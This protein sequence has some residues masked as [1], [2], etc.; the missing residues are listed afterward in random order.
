MK[1]GLICVMISFLIGCTQFQELINPQIASKNQEIEHL[2]AQL[3][4][5]LQTN[6]AVKQENQKLKSDNFRLMR[7]N[8][9]LEEDIRQLKNTNSKLK[10]ENRALARKIDILK[11]LDHHVEEKR[12]IYTSD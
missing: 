4:K 1:A 6:R 10:T 5:S 7:D 11:I 2:T 12:K 9:Q 3:Q 8:T